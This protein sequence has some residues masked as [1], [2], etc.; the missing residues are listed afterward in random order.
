MT[1]NRAQKELLA[2]DGY[3]VVPGV[4]PR[5]LVDAALREINHSLGRPKHP[6]RDAYADAQDYLSAY[7]KSP[8]VMGLLLKSPAW[9]LAESLLGAGN[10]EEVNQAQLA[11][12]FPS[13]DDSSPANR[14]IHVDG[15]Y[16]KRHGV[17]SPERGKTKVRYT[18]ALGVML[19][20]APRPG[21]GNLCVY[22]GAHRLLAERIKAEGLKPLPGGLEKA[23]ALPAP[24]QVTGRAG[25]V[26]VFNYQLPHDKERNDSA[27]IRYM[28]YFRLWHKDAWADASLPATRRALERIWSEW[29]GMR[30]VRGT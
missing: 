30:G 22:P 11:L 9:A 19:S 20:D 2:R 27:E 28:V 14:T 3:L 8:A 16:A 17:F 7:V 26:V 5:A 1:L 6:S 23:L 21:M 4:V 12:R 25:D 24:V 13:R 10:I 18:M 29:P 15:L